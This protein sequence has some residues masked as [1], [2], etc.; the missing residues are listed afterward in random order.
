GVGLIEKRSVAWWAGYSIHFTIAVSILL[1]SGSRR[2][3]L[4]PLLIMFAIFHYFKSEVSIKRACGV[5]ALL[6]VI[7][8]IYGVVRMGR[9]VPDILGRDLDMYERESLTYHFKYGLLPLE[10]MLDA[11]VIDPHYGSTFLAAI[12]NFV[13]RPLWPGKP[14]SAG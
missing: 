13:P 12:T 4:M 14:D 8:S 3:F 6:L 9:R 5:L 7:T 11:D 2:Y 10:V 1:M